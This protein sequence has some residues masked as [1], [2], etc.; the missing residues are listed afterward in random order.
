MQEVIAGKQ[1]WRGTHMVVVSNAGYTKSAMEL[2]STTG[3]LLISDTEL[4]VMH[5]K[6]KDFH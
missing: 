1:Y 5:D 6:L 3:V 2:A 4:S